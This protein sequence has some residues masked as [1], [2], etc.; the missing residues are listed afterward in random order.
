MKEAFRMKIYQNKSDDYIA[1]RLNDNGYERRYK[2][3]KN[4][5]TYLNSKRLSD[6]WTDEFYYGI[7]NSG[8]ASSDQR[9][10]NPY[11]ESLITVDEY[12]ILWD[13]YA[14]K[15]KDLS[16]KKIKEE[17]HE[18]MPVSRG[19]VID[20]DGYAMSFTLPNR[21]NRFVPKVKELQKHDSSITLAD[22][23]KP[24]QLRYDAQNKSSS[25]K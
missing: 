8:G 14:K 7:L 6:I 2:N 24:K 22:I 23:V 1:D 13:R 5:I 15:T 25:M 4:K 3:N 11:Y 19:K 10:Q 18:I 21:N 9:E 12:Q 16:P 20:C 17:L